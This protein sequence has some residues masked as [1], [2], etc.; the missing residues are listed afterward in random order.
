MIAP[1]PMNGFARRADNETT[2]R[3]PPSV[4]SAW[5]TT[6]RSTIHPVV[7]ASVLVRLTRAAARCNAPP[8]TAKAFTPT[9]RQ[10]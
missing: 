2:T 4:I 1:S 9:A 10:M 6:A 3:F 8:A 5:P 7:S